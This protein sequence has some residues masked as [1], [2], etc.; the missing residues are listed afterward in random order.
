M[1]FALVGWPAYPPTKNGEHNENMQ[2]DDILIASYSGH[3]CSSF[4]V[5]IDGYESH[6][7]AVSA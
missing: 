5:D 2:V 6:D 4:S 3:H 7:I 1:G